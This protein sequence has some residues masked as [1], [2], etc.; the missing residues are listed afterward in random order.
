M[1]TIAVSTGALSEALT[2]TDLPWRYALV[3]MAATAAFGVLVTLWSRR[4]HPQRFSAMAVPHAGLRS[5]A[6]TGSVELLR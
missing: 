2:V 4:L 6:V 3:D 5:G 1:L